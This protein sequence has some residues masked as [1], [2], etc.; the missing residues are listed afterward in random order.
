MGRVVK[1]LERATRADLR[2]A[3]FFIA[4]LVGLS[5]VLFSVLKGTAPS[6]IFPF[7]VAAIVLGTV[8]LCC[9]IYKN[10]PD[11]RPSIFILRKIALSVAYTKIDRTTVIRTTKDPNVLHRI[12]LVAV[13]KTIELSVI[14]TV[15]EFDKWA[16]GELVVFRIMEDVTNYRTFFGLHVIK[17]TNPRGFYSIFPLKTDTYEY[18]ATRSIPSY[19]DIRDAD[20]AKTCLSV[21]TDQ[22]VTSSSLNSTVKD[23]TLF[24]LDFHITYM[25]KVN[26]QKYVYL[27]V[28]A[29]EIIRR[30]FTA[31]PRISKIATIAATGYG[32]K[33]ADDLGFERKQL[34]KSLQFKGHEENWYFYTME[35][36]KF[37]T[38][39][40]AISQEAASY[41]EDRVQIVSRYES[42]DQKTLGFF[43]KFVTEAAKSALGNSPD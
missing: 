24:I 28:D 4:S 35:R 32:V 26:R 9:E 43:R 8:L 31:D 20:M 2:F 14:S 18:L 3:F 19:N 38:I 41:V 13:G 42:S 1:A 23:I 15:K 10:S 17:I 5:N 12:L 40:N 39:Y 25:E 29:F 34:Y 37:M 6:Q 36:K 30:M 16:S 11:L 7:I 33:F 27:M 21:G 22:W